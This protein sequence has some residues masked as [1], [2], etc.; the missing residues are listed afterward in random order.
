MVCLEKG[1]HLTTSP[2][3]Y[4][5]AGGLIVSV[6]VF[7]RITN[8]GFSKVLAFPLS[9]SSLLETSKVAVS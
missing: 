6:D 5:R 2:I 8:V 1:V 4:N 9:F 7:V 3:R